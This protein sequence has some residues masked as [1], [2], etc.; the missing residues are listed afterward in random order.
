MVAMGVMLLQAVFTHLHRKK[1][2]WLKRL[3]AEDA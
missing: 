1:T 2:F 3:T